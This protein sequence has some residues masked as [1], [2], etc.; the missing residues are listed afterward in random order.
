MNAKDGITSEE[1]GMLNERL[2]I[3]RG[4][5]RKFNENKAATSEKNREDGV[6]TSRM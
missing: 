4:K 3:K 5:R 2:K 1:N 6:Y